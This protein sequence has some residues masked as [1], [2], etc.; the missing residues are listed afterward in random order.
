MESNNN[1]KDVLSL[2]KEIYHGWGWGLDERFIN[3]IKT[4]DI[5]DFA[6][7]FHHGFG[8]QIRNDYGL[9]AGDTDLYRYFIALGIKHPDDMSHKVFK[10]L[11]KYGRQE[12][13]GEP[14]VV[15]D[16]EKH[17]AEFN[18]IGCSKQDK[19]CESRLINGNCDA[20][21]SCKWQIL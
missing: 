8:T 5:G 3:D 2:V 10:E 20:P 14:Y 16:L 13:L 18:K 21:D 9:W 19:K 4:K 17:I 6:I 15:I 1:H 7:Q 12:L 11:Y